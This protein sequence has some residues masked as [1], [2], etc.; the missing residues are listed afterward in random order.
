LQETENVAYRVAWWWAGR[1]CTASSAWRTGELHCS[2]N[3]LDDG[4][5]DDDRTRHAALPQSVP[6]LPRG[7]RTQHSYRPPEQRQPLSTAAKTNL[8]TCWRYNYNL[9]LQKTSEITTRH[10]IYTRSTL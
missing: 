3:C 7:S 2:W 9:Y 8:S 4:R 1:C 10:Q 5:A 6:G